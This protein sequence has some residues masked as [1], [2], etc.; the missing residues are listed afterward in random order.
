VGRED[1]T[2]IEFRCSPY[3]QNTALYPVIEH[4]QRFLQFHRKDSPQE[5]LGK[6]GISFAV[7]V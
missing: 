3:Y 6:L 4:I 2:R 7:F 1:C 5:K